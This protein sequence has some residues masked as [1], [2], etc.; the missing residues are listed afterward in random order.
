MITE[1]LWRSH[2]GEDPAIVGRPV[3]VAGTVQTIVGV[4]PEESVPSNA[5]FFTPL[6]IDLA[7]EDRSNHLAQVLGA[8]RPG[9]R[10]MVS[11]GYF[12]PMRIPIVRGEFFS[13]HTEA[14]RS[15]MIVSASMAQRLWG[16]SDVV[17]RQV[18][19]G[20][21][22]IFTIIGVVGDVR[23]L[24]LAL[25]PEPTMYISTARFT[26]ATM[27][28]SFA[29]ASAAS[30]TGRRSSGPWCASSI[31]SSRSSTFSRPMTV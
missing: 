24:E 14:D 11:P 27:T 15:T 30:R 7:Q 5:D 8:L 23:N 9:A 18:A 10:R 28:W 3:T 22:G 19:A 6:R 4:V 13:G 21:A 1:G 25:A 26:W 16:T 31:R 20:P 2:F 29:A 12:A 17:G